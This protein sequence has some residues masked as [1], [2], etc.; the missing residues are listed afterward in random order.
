MY[1]RLR[2]GDG[3]YVWF[4]RVQECI[5]TPEAEQITSVAPM[6]LLVKIGYQ[7]PP[8]AWWLQNAT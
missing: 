8:C 1:P 4:E 2:K 7:A 5:Q 6:F 3:F